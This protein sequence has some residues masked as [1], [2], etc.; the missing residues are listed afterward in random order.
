MFSQITTPIESGILSPVLDFLLKFGSGVIVPCFLG[1]IGYLQIRAKREVLNVKTAL[2]AS[3]ATT[4]HKLEKIDENTN[5]HVT[6]LMDRIDDLEKA[7]TKSQ[8]DNADN[9]RERAAPEKH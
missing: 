9:A 1:W 7:L 2:V 3:D 6:R 8:S 4:K 5:G